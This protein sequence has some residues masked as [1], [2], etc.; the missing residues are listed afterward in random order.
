MENKKPKCK[1]IG[2]D[3]SVFAL[4]GKA[5]R[6]LKDAGLKEQ[7]TKMAN[8]VMA[9]GSYDEALQIMMRYVEVS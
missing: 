3:G 2:T 1:L 9:A 8:E 4:L 5:S 6:A 7:A